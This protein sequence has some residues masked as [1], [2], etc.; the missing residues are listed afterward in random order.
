MAEGRNVLFDISMASP[1]AFQSW[2]TALRRARYTVTGMFIDISIEESVRRTEAEH[3]RKHEEYRNGI[4]YGGRYIRPDAI[5]AL[6]ASTGSLAAAQAAS[7]AGLPPL[8]AALDDQ[9]ARAAFPGGA[10]TGMIAAYQ[11]GQ[12]SLGDLIVGFRARRWPVVPPACPP[13]L[14]QAEPAIDDPEPYVPSS[15]DDVILAY[16]LGQLA[17]HDYQALASAAAR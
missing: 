14:E 8:A 15:F 2:T 1:H 3:R 12:L 9:S 4:G 11:A 13:G 7:A 16:D 17:D 10:V 6:A 5:R